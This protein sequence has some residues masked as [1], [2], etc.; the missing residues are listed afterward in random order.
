MDELGELLY[1]LRTY[2]TDVKDGTILTYGAE[3]LKAL[4]GTLN[5]AISSIVSLRSI[6]EH[7]AAADVYVNRVTTE[8]V[9]YMDETTKKERKT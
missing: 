6:I 1:L 7:H 9:W 4:E 3:D 8:N 5:W 2:R